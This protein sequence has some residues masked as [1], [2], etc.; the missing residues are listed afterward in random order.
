MRRYA[1]F[2]TSIHGTAGEM[3][4]KFQAAGLGCRCL[5]SGLPS[6]GRPQAARYARTTT[7]SA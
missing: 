7:G 2:V 3:A 5:R 4:C 1:C 6:P